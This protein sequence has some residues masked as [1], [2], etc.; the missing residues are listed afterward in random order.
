VVP[1]IKVSVNALLVP[2]VVRDSQGHAVGGLRKEDF[3]VFD[4]GKPR[5]ISGFS[6]ETRASQPLTSH[7]AAQ[8]F[9]APP[10]PA[11]PTSP[12]S[13]ASA[14]RFIV[15]LF[16]ELH[17]SVLDLAQAQKAADRMVSTSLSDSDFA[18][19]VSFSGVSSGLTLDKTKLRDA[20]SKLRVHELYRHSEQSCP[21]IDYYVADLIVNKRDQA[22]FDSAVEETMSCAHLTPNMRPEAEGMVR[23]ASGQALSL[24]DQ[25]MRVTLSTVRQVVAK[26]A[27]LPGQR[28]LV[29]ISPGFLTVTM[30]A[31]AAKSQILDLAA[32]SNVTVSALDARGLHVGGRDVSAPPNATTHAQISGQ[33]AR[34]Q[35]DRGEYSDVLAE[36]ADGTGGT[37]IHNTNDLDGGLHRLTTAPECVYL[38]EVSL[39]D[40]K[41][42]STFHSLKVKIDRPRMQV[43]ARRGY[44][45]P[46]AG[47]GKK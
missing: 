4:R 2:V 15:L 13:V 23:A 30:E 44:M 11:T 39:Q 8:G 17:L 29:L 38:L 46:A 37:F 25:D 40:V 16:D 9:T 3:Q 14:Q 33:A 20:I 31:M 41:P 45:A 6:V 27:D 26:M 47:G 22:A 1:A 43:Q 42:D 19:V 35:L 12:P 7:A 21:D 28:L 5:E 24:G 18:A 36:L 34:R 10:T 32:R